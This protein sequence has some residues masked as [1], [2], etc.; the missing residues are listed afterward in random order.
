MILTDS[1]KYILKYVLQNKKMIYVFLVTTL[2]ITCIAIL[3]PL[4]A[5][6]I[7]DLTANINNLQEIISLSLFWLIIFFIKNICSFLHKKYSLKHFLSVTKSVQKNLFQQLLYKPIEFYEKNSIGYITARLIDDTAALE[8]IMLNNIISGIVAIFEIFIIFFFMFKI[9]IIWGIFSLI[10]QIINLYINFHFPLKTLYKNNNEQKALHSKFIQDTLSGILVIK[11]GNAYEKECA[12]YSRILNSW[13]NT[14]KKRDRTN[15]IRNLLSNFSLEFSTMLIILLGSMSVYYQ[16]NT[17]GDI[18]AFLL[19]F[20]TLNSV[21]PNAINLIPLYKIS[22]GAADRIYEFI[23]MNNEITEN[24]AQIKHSPLIGAV[25][26]SNVC[27]QKNGKVILN[28]ISLSISPKSMIV[29]VGKS[30]SGKTTI[31]NLLL[32]F[33][34]ETKGNIYIDKKDINDYNLLDLRASIAYLTQE[35][36]IFNRSIW[37]NITYYKSIN[38]IAEIKDLLIQTASYDMIHKLPLGMETIIKSDLGN[39]SGGEKQ[40]IALVRELLKDAKIIIFDEA[41]ASVDPITER[42][43]HQTIVELSMQSTVI[44]ITHKLSIAKDADNIY[45][46]KDGSIEESGTH[47]TLLKEKG[48]YYKLVKEAG[49]GE[50]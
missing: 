26:F 1:H 22:Q 44:V 31:A 45:V 25:D 14:W 12:N 5:K 7:I 18:M 10:L 41:T 35:A 19:F 43:I 30:G 2:T 16:W 8:G 11:L 37:D 28:N 24:E 27:L 48:E 50:F 20:Q 33:I 9:S 23:K 39:L 13:Y 34:K 29:F 6:K 47:T 49:N 38:D 46:L 21:L 36:I 42:I 17:I 32:R 15:Y 40:R 3:E 4:I